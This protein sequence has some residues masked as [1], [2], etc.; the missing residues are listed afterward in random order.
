MPRHN[1]DEIYTKR[2]ADLTP[3]PR[4]TRAR[5]R[6]KQAEDNRTRLL[7]QEG[8]DKKKEI[9]FVF[10]LFYF[11]TIF[12]IREEEQVEIILMLFN[13]L[14]K[15]LIVLFNIHLKKNLFVFELI[16]NV[17]VGRLMLKVM[18]KLSIKVNVHHKL[19]AINIHHCL[20]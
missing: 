9:S 11:T 4:R 16:L 5:E 17:F 13:Y 6:I 12:R 18:M 7:E 3:N 1:D 8:Y 20:T 19:N 10:G 2:L 14:K 15:L